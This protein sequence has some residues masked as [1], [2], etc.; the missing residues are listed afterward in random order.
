MDMEFGEAFKEI[1]SLVNGRIVKLKDMEYILGLMVIG[2][3]VSGRNALEMVMVLIFLQ[4]EIS[5]QVN[6]KMENLKV[7]ECIN[8]QMEIRTK[9]SLRMEWNMVKV[10]GVKQQK[11]MIQKE[12]KILTKDTFLKIK[13]MVMENSNGIQAIFTEVITMKMNDKDMVK[14][15]G[16]MVVLIMDIGKTACNTELV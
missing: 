11:K 10:D 1:L 15:F 6:I 12:D 13:N 14:W 5:I 8:G 9:V 4:M 2:M 3:K 16:L 7:L